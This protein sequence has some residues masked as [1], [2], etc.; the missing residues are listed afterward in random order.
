MS[1]LADWTFLDAPTGGASRPSHK[2]LVSGWA[3]PGKRGCGLSPWQRTWP[4]SGSPFLGWGGL[5]AFFALP[6]LIA[7]A[8]A[9]SW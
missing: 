3:E 7:L 8:I 5:A 6:T 4:I 1:N 2:L 9:T